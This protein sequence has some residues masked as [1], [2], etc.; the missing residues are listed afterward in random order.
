MWMRNTM[1]AAAATFALLGCS[2]DDKTA[3]ERVVSSF[4]PQSEGESEGLMLPGEIGALPARG[5]PVGWVQTSAAYPTGWA[6]AAER[7]CAE[8]LCEIAP[9]AVG[10]GPQP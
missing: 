2:R 6:D 7:R 4:T 10:G 8:G 5:G 9:T 3:T 1:V